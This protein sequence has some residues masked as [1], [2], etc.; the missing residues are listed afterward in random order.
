MVTL[1]PITFEGTSEPRMVL[2]SIV[3]ILDERVALHFLELVVCVWDI[4]NAV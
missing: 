3:F 1:S 2:L 4:H